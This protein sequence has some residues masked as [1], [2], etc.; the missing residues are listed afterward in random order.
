[1][2]TVEAMQN[3]GAD[4][5]TGISRCANKDTLYLR[6][7]KMVPINDGFEKL[8]AAI[9]AKDL[10]AG[11]QA[12]HGLKGILANLSITPLLDP[13]VEITE[14]LRNKTDADYSPLI[15]KIKEERNKLAEI[16]K[17]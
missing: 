16:C 15:E 5:A 9:E 2:L 13:V 8:Y 17:D 14:L 1:M 4:T 11:F 10:E 3:Y 12:A 7:V 6:L